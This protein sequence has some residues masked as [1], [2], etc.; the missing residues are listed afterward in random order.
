MTRLPAERRLARLLAIVP[1]ILAQD[2]PPVEEVCRRFEVNERELLAD[3]NLLFLCGVYPFTPDTLIE[4]DFAGGRVWIRFADW[5]S[6][7]LRLSPPEALALVSAARVLSVVPGSDPDGALARG[8]AKLETVIG[9]GE[10]E[11][12]DVELGPVSSG[13]LEALQEALAGRRKLEIDYY[14]FGRDGRSRRVVRPWRVFN[15]RGQWY[16]NGWCEAAGGER[17]FRVDRIN[18]AH[19]LGDTFER[20]PQVEVTPPLYRGRPDDPVVVLSLSPGARWIAEQHP[21][22]DLVEEGDGGL[23]VTLRVSGQAWLE[24]LLLQG[25]NQVRVIEGD[26]GLAARVAERVLK[27]YERHS[28]PVS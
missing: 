3:L 11:G 17:L 6:R 4:V 24:R 20:D 26:H 1:W 7:P 28:E 15:S 16:L 9:I 22:E 25:G 23:Q 14:S 8:L 12:F 18:E 5:F 27:R 2:G 19:L 10:D 21:Y 13:V